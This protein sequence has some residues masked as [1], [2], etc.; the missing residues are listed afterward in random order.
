MHRQ[1]QE[2]VATHRLFDHAIVLWIW[3]T[4]RQDGS[5][6]RKTGKR[7]ETAIQREVPVGSIKIRVVEKIEGIRLKFQRNA[8]CHGEI[9][10]NRN[11]K[12]SL[13]R[14]TEEIASVGSV[15][16]FKVIASRR[17][18]GAPSRAAAGTGRGGCG[19]ARCPAGAR[20]AGS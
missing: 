3:R 18:G 5:W 2:A 20:S 13:E 7:V 4:R 10:D 8:L 9:L 15:T 19:R 12:T 1:L 17:A 6:I 11:V 14:S 16:C